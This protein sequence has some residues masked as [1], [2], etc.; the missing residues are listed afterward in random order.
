MDRNMS[1]SSE[2]VKSFSVVNFS[3][4]E[5][6]RDAT[7][8]NAVAPDADEVAPVQAVGACV[9]TALDDAKRAWR[10]LA[11]I[12]APRLGICWNRIILVGEN[13]PRMLLCAFSR[14]Q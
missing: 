6:F 1:C 3:P 12:A 11:A 7:A 4:A 9:N 14:G 5:N 2:G 8:A 13:A 10:F